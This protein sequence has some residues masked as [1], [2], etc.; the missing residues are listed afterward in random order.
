MNILVQKL[1]ALS[2]VLILAAAIY[3]STGNTLYKVDLL[4]VI[5]I[6]ASI[7]RL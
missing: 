2:G 7:V 1:N 5:G 4:P 3:L 6:P